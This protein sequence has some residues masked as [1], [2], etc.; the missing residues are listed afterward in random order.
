M[1]SN[2]ISP[3]VIKRLPRYYRFLG[4]LISENVQRI[5]SGELAKRMGLTAS[6]I[7]QDLNCFGGFGQQGFGYN[8]VDLHESISKILGLKDVAKAVLIGAGNLG[9]A[10]SAHMEF[11]D[12]GFKLI[13]IFDKNEA[14]AGSILGEIP[15]RNMTVLEEFC[16]E[17]KPTIAILCIPKE[18]AKN[19]VE[20]LIA[21]GV[22]GFWNFTHYD[23]AVN[24]EGVIVENVHLS[25]SMM[26]LRYQMK[27]K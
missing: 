12:Y 19:V 20:E 21:L 5:S 14:L 4:E 7:R 17:Q 11:E 6:Q 24:H 27:N 13:G 26:T 8:V 1:T 15:V 9:K 25:D 23:I 16:R 18:A 3:N 10:L 22:R 2:A